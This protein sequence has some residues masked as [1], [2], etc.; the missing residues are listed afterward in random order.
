[1]RLFK[2]YLA[3]FTPK[4]LWVFLI[5]G[6]LFL[7]TP[8]LGLRFEPKASYHVCFTSTRDCTQ[9]I[10]HAIQ[11]AKH[12]IHVQ[13][14]LMTSEPIIKA[15]LGAKARKVDVQVILDKTYSTDSPLVK[16][17]RQAAI[18]VW[19]DRVPGIAHNKVMIIDH[20]QVLTGSF[21]FTHAA[22]KRNRENVL[23]L[24]DSALAKQ[25]LD[26]WHYCK[27]RATK[28]PSS[29]RYQ[30]SAQEAIL[31]DKDKRI[32]IITVSTILVIALVRALNG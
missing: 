18:P 2:A 3:H 28:I 22:G 31:S 14:Y 30:A 15:L 26:N 27:V 29:V 23:L 21:N 17:L 12:T 7:P 10:V 11:G 20:I 4:K 6:C 19:I 1:M 32:I 25:Y 24:S 13:A 8:S 9:E 16:R 5:I